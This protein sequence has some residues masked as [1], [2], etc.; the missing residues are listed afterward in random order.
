MRPGGQL[1]RILRSL[2]GLR[3]AHLP[4]LR[5]DRGHSVM[6][7]PGDLWRMPAPIDPQRP[8]RAVSHFDGMPGHLS[9]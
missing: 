4:H 1:G 3:W 9:A 2:S 8:G 7:T 5:P 6:D